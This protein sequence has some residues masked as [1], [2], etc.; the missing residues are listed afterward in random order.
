MSA[1]I[2]LN[3]VYDEVGITRLKYGGVEQD[4]EKVKFNYNG[5]IFIEYY[6]NKCFQ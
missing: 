2:E 4:E 6:A 5:G 1:V 3:Q